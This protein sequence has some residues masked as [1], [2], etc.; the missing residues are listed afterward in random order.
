MPCL[1]FF[2]QRLHQLR[3]LVHEALQNLPRRLIGYVAVVVDQPVLELNVGLGPTKQGR[4]V[5]DEDGSQMTLRYRRADRA[6][7]R[8]GDGTYL[9]LEL[10]LSGRARRPV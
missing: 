4:H 9:A 5:A 8:A 3:K 2:R 10:A 1:L 6:A 7:R